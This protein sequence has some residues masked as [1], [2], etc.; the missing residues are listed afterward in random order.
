MHLQRRA[1]ITEAESCS[2][3]SGSGRCVCRAC[4]GRGE[5]L[6][7]LRACSNALVCAE[8]RLCLGHHQLPQR[9]SLA[10]SVSPERAVSAAASEPSARVQ[11]PLLLRLTPCFIAGRVNQMGDD[12]LPEGVWPQWYAKR[13]EQLACSCF[14]V[15]GFL[16]VGGRGANCR[17]EVRVAGVTRAEGAACG[18]AGN[19]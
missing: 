7:L 1:D 10:S 11:P 5:L 4:R 19:V 16:T 2:A 18:T 17:R 3:C 6:S 12:M 13:S 14:V 15:V 8:A 9:S